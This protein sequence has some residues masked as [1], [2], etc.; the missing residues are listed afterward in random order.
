MIFFKIYL[1]NNKS[2]LK[3]L[4]SRIGSLE[5][6]EKFGLGF[7]PNDKYVIEHLRKEGFSD[8]EIKNSDLLI[9]NKDNKF[10]GRFKERIIFPIYS[11]NDRIVGLGLD[12]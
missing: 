12:H 4:E 3:Y 7:C 9:R 5:I 11:F 10:F 8:D 6:V 2:A 1:K